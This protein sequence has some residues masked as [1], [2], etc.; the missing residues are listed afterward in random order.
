MSFTLSPTWMPWVRTAPAFS[1]RVYL[2]GL[3]ET[4]VGTFGWASSM[5]STTFASS[6]MKIRS[7]GKA[8]LRHGVGMVDGPGIH[9]EHAPALGHGR[10]MAEPA[11][12]L[13][14]IR[15]QLDQKPPARGFASDEL[16]DGRAGIPASEHRRWDSAKSVQTA[17]VGTAVAIRLA[18]AARHAF[19][20]RC[21]AGGEY[22]QSRNQQAR[23]KYPDRTP[24]A[25]VQWCA[26][27]RKGRN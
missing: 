24:V 21:F 14:P 1:S 11:S 5:M 2:Y 16:D 6:P 17:V 8:H 3:E 23:R 26:W 20:P 9:E 22:G 15:C 25:Q 13:V 10:A 12:L 4:K 18:R 7:R 27:S 19:F